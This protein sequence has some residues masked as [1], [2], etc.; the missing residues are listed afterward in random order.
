MGVAGGELLIP[1]NILLF[2]I[3][4]KIAGSLSLASRCRR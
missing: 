1:T 2:G 3:D 4:I